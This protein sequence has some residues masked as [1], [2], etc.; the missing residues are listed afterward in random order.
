MLKEIA[1]KNGYTDR[2]L[3]EVL[4]LIN[5]DFTSMLIAEVLC[6]GHL[7]E[8]TALERIKALGID[9]GGISPADSK[10]IIL[11][12]NEWDCYYIHALLFSVDCIVNH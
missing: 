5:D 10:K 6:D 2:K 3:L 11:S 4:D 12:L 9:M 7:C 1:I 8:Y